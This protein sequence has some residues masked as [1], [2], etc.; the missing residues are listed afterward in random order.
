MNIKII[1][2]SRFSKETSCFAR[3]KHLGG[4]A[5]RSFFNKVKLWEGY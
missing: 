4:I 1:F 2:E 5:G 3:M